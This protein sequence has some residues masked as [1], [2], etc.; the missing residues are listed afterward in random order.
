MIEISN[1]LPTVLPFSCS[2]KEGFTV[3]SWFF[4][5]F[6]NFQV[7]KQHFDI[8]IKGPRYVEVANCAVAVDAQAQLLCYP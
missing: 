5:Y 1:E 4:L 3:M 2:M 6:E 7:K 8:T